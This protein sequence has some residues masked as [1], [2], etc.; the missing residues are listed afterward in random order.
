M[1]AT[2]IKMLVNFSIF[3]SV[4]NDISPSKLCLEHRI[5]LDNRCVY[6]AYFFSLTYIDR[7]M[8]NEKEPCALF[9]VVYVLNSVGPTFSPSLAIGDDPNLLDLISA[10]IE[11]IVGLGS[12]VE[13]IANDY[14][15][16]NVKFIEIHFLMKYIVI[17][18]III[19]DF[20]L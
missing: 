16:Y 8:H 5:H 4:S 10:L 18:I 13:R 9:M 12:C 1:S 3:F 11:N 17:I 20:Y 19:M 14:P 6:F 7:E 15:P 2:R